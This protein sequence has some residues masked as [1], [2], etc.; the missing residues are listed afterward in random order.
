MTMYSEPNISECPA[1]PQGWYREVV[2][3]MGGLSAGR[4]DVYYYSPLGQKVRRR[5]Q[6]NLVHWRIY[7]IFK[8]A[9]QA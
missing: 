3:R 1:L 5:L 6:Q 2:P 8:G 7:F 9:E 4:H